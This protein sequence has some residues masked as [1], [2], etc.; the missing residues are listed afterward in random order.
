MAVAYI[1]VGTNIEREHHLR[2]AIQALHGHFPDLLCSSV[3]ESEAV[4]FDGDPFYNLVVRV[5]TDMALLEVAAVLQQIENTQGRDRSQPRFSSRVIDLDLLL[6]DD[7]IFDNGKLQIPREEILHNAFVLWPLAEI[8][9]EEIHPQLKRSYAALWQA[10]D[11][12]KQP[13]W[14]VD[15]KV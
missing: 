5:C 8:A 3:Y 10:F 11:R 12:R 7:Q 9:G 15:F 1:S 14:V 4:G 2:L 13:I 6:Y